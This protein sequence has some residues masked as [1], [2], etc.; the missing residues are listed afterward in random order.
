MH[1]CCEGLQFDFAQ[2]GPQNRVKQLAISISKTLAKGQEAA[3]PEA[4]EQTIF[5]S[6]LLYDMFFIAKIVE[7]EVPWFIFSE[8]QVACVR[9]LGHALV[10]RIGSF[11]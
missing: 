5:F 7:Q 6:P 9:L 2:K 4:L 8:T 11:K 3:Y 10:H 1:R